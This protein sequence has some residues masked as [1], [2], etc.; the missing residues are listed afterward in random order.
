MNRSGRPVEQ[1]FRAPS[2]PASRC[3]PRQLTAP[4]SSKAGALAAENVLK[5]SGRHRPE[6][7]INIVSV[8]STVSLLFREPGC[9]L[10]TTLTTACPLTDVIERQAQTTSVWR[11]R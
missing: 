2:Q 3:L 10:D 6:L 1:R 9:R 8:W 5:P 4:M 7:G 11:D